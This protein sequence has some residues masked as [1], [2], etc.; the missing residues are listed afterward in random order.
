MRGSVWC[1]AL[2]AL[3]LCAGCNKP[4][5]SCDGTLNSYAGCINS[6]DWEC[7]IDLFHPDQ[8]AKYGD[9][10]I[11]KWALENWNGAR[12]FKWK[13][14]QADASGSV[15]IARTNAYYEVKIR[16]KN[17]ETYDNWGD[18]Y[19]LHLKDGLWYMDIPG[20]QKV[21]GF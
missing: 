18:T 11:R 20:S 4:K 7:L 3:V 1:A 17:P 15:C 5:D 12:N 2:A 13:F 9:K 10:M 16:G 6:Q 21:Q 19:T 14:V 8:R